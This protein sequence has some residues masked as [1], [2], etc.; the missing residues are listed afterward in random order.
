[1]IKNLI[2]NRSNEQSYIYTVKSFDGVLSEDDRGFSET[3]SVLL[4]SDDF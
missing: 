4:E 3:E 1:M 2:T